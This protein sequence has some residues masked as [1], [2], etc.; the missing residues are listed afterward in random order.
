[1][2]P[3][4]N[5]VVYRNEEGEVLGWDNPSYDEPEYCDACGYTHSSTACPMDDDLEYDDE[6]DD[7]CHC[8]HPDCGA[9]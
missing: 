8:G 4:A 9:C 2:F 5:S 3:T 7:S 1:M 6:E